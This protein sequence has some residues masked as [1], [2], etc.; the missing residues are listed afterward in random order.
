MSRLPDLISFAQLHGLKIGT[1]ADLIAFR[2]R[3]DTLIECTIDEPFKSEY[4]G[5]WR[6]RVYFNKTEQTEHL[7]L[8]KGE[9]DGSRPVMV[10]VHAIN[11]LEDLFGLANG[12]AHQL[13]A[14]M[15]EIARHGSGVVVMP[16]EGEGAHVSQYLAKERHGAVPGNG[17]L[18]AYG[19]GCLMLSDLGIKDIILLTNSRT[20]AFVGLEGFGLRVVEE[21][22]IPPMSVLGVSAS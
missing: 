1:I 15:V 7:A 8:V 3:H 11:L 22:P 18:R 20:H 10:R 16:R 12:R 19:L 14:A 4:G 6:I 2:R 9:V 21:R 13:N 17:M 5:D